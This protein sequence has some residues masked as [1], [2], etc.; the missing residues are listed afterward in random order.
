[1][2]WPFE[3]DTSAITKKLAKRFLRAEKT[4][5]RIL[6]LT[7]AISTVLILAT[8]LILV[9]FSE[10]HK[11]TQRT[12]AQITM[13]ITQ[14]EQLEALKAQPEVE[15]AGVYAGLGFSYQND[16][17]LNVLYEDETQLRNQE[18]V[19]FTG[20]FP[21][22]ENEI[23]LQES[24]I[25]YLQNDIEIGDK[26]KLD[27]T[28]LGNTEEY[29]VSGIVNSTSNGTD[30][31]VWVSEDKAQQI[32]VDGVIPRTA[33]VRLNTDVID[34][35]VLQSMGQDLAQ[36]CGILEQSVQI[37]NDYYAVMSGSDTGGT[38]TTI[39]PVALT[40]LVLAGIVIYSIF[41]VS[42]SKNVRNFGQLRTLGLTKK[43][44]KKMMWAES[45]SMLAKGIIGG[46]FISGVIGFLGNSSGFRI[47]N[48]LW[49]GFIVAICICFMTLLAVRVP[50]KIAANISP[51]EGTK[52][53]FY[54]AKNSKTSK[55]KRKTRY[56]LTPKIL[57]KINLRRS[58]KKTILTTIMLSLSGIIF[59][60]VVTV[61]N[62]LSAEKMARFYMF[63]NG[64]LQL[65]I[66]SVETSTFD[67]NGNSGD[68]VSELQRENNP[69]N[70]E[71]LNQLYSIQGVQKVTAENAVNLYIQ[72]QENTLFSSIAGTGGLTSTLT[73]EQCEM[74]ADALIEGT[75]DYDT[76]N[77]TNGILIR[78]GASSLNA[79]DVVQL[80]GT[81]ASGNEFHIEVPVIGIFEQ[82]E[83]Q[84]VLPLSSGSDFYVTDVTAQNLTGIV[85]QTGIVSISSEDGY[86]QQVS[87][88]IK[89]LSDLNNQIDLYTLENSVSTR[90][91]LFDMQIQPLFMIALILFLFS[92]ISLTNT[93]LTNLLE[94][95]QELALLQSV[96]MTKN[97]QQKMIT[98]EEHFY[99]RIAL[100]STV[101]LGSILSAGICFY[102]ENTSHCI[103]FQYP[104]LIVIAFLGVIVVAD[105]LVGQL[106]FQ[107][108]VKGKLIDRLHTEE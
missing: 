36:R 17:I 4:S 68:R 43:Q 86:E 99:L 69:L 78:K 31:F 29:T 74:I 108:T 54:N 30:Y 25:K 75:S 33:Y 76:L 50:T 42:V 58:L 14:P 41:Y 9:G 89:G 49:Y 23:L 62:S 59:V 7:I 67:T 65:R 37:I 8:I 96:G 5:R 103:Q 64:D 56:K 39:L 2:T 18:R 27:L 53:T 32:A 84:Q 90:Q 51:L 63:P 93:Q 11:D 105:F 100:L 6:T 13:A 87:E 22:Q 91:A 12:K 55:Q 48:F 92:V 40:V 80:S 24:Y 95:K 16:I 94:R 97:Q 104:W 70:D 83:Q 46:I 101:I 73:Q 21:L 38:I 34:I 35:P 102:I 79:G 71:L 107:T 57:G 28:G 19:E 82:G 44:M 45:R 20:Q 10:A 88:V 106:A 1:M 85:D 52:F 66:Q 15:W 60:T 72:Y 47:S 3:N 61:A 77:T 81:D 26:I 98:T